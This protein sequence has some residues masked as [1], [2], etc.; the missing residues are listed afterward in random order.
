MGICLDHQFLWNWK[1]WSQQS[2][3][4]REKRRG[5]QDIGQ[6]PWHASGQKSGE[7][8]QLGIHENPFLHVVF[9][10][11][12]VHHACLRLSLEFFNDSSEFAWQPVVVR[13]EER[14]DV[15]AR[16]PQTEIKRRCLPSIRLS[17]I[18]D[19]GSILLQS[20]RSVVGRSVI[21]N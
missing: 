4:E 16:Q 14:N 7:Q 1:H 10:N 2:S 17:E 13:I 19:V 21:Y 6:Q 18:T 15:S 5:I 20:S 9:P 12:V 3:T 11:R 8:W